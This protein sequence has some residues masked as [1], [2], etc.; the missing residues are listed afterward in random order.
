MR[1]CMPRTRTNAN[2]PI[3]ARATDNA[4]R[5]GDQFMKRRVLVEQVA[6]NGPPGTLGKVVFGIRANPGPL[7][8]SKFVDGRPQGIQPLALDHPLPDQESVMIERIQFVGGG[9]NLHLANP[10]RGR[11]D[12]PSSD[13][14]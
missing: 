7:S 2:G 4:V 13:H 14:R 9:M 12:D 3:M 8:F 6:E 10:W 5:P 11:P 1:A